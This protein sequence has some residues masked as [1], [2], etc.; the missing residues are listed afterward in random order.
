VCYLATV[1]YMPIN[2]R[3][4]NPLSLFTLQLEGICSETLGVCVA[5]LFVLAACSYVEE[6][7]NI[8][9]AFANCIVVLDGAH[10]L[11]E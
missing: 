9:F 4:S 8:Q 5:I 10:P 2:I 6:T 3:S 7:S 1:V 11:F